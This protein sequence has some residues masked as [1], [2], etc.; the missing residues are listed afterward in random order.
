[1]GYLVR[2]VRPIF[3]RPAANPTSVQPE[4]GVRG[5]MDRDYA[6]SAR[7]APCAPTSPAISFEFF[8]R[9]KPRRWRRGLWETI[10]RLAPLA[11][12]FVSVTYGAGGSNARAHPFHHHP[13]SR[14]KTDLLPAAA[15]DLRGR[16]ARRDRRDRRPLSRCRRP[17]YRRPCAAI[18]PAASARPTP[19]IRTAYRTS[20]D[21]VAGIKRQHG[22]I[23]K[24]RSPPIPK[25]HPEKPRLRWA[26]NRCF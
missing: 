2:L 16:G 10:K 18:R 17:P 20:A 4:W 26:D 25:K 19:R 23:S 1:M 21:L 11:P 12:S 6:D 24:F 22:D 8:S 5:A 9:R 15:S 14:G 13:Y 7:R 3:M